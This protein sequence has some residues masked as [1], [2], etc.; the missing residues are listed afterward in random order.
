MKGLCSKCCSSNEECILI[1]GQ[2]FCKK[3]ERYEKALNSL[4]KEDDE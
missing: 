3:C 2:M 4:G 1:E